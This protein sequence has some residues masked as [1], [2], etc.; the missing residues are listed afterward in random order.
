MSDPLR[1]RPSIARVPSTPTS[2]LAP[3]VT[4]TSVLVVPT[5]YAGQRTPTLL[6]STM[7]DGSGSGGNPGTSLSS[8]PAPMTGPVFTSS[9]AY[10]DSRDLSF[11]VGVPGGFDASPYF[12]ASA[13]GA[14]PHAF[15]PPPPPPQAPR[16]SA[17]SPPPPPQAVP[18][19]TAPLSLS[20]LAAASAV[21]PAAPAAAS[22]VEDDDDYDPSRP[23]R[24][25]AAPVPT[26]GVAIMATNIV[27]GAVVEGAT[28]GASNSLYAPANPLP[29]PKK[30]A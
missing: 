26:G 18:R 5:A 25:P 10:D 16:V 9:G 17:L 1:T 20:A 29:V 28:R 8:S 12:P 23:P 13:V 7:V 30:S 19:T 27:L 14:S 3:V 22:E 6:A 2:P 15:A 21:T 24:V 11:A 4:G